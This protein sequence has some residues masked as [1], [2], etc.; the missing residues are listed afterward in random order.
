LSL[1]AGDL[2]VCVNLPAPA[3]YALHKL[4]VFGERTGAFATKSAKD[5]QQAASLLACLK[6]MRKSDVQRAWK[7][8]LSRG[9]GWRSRALAGV[10]ALDRRYPELGAAAWLK[11]P[12]R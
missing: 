4:L 11:A 1:S 9:K 6:V 2:V 7:D 5:L 3:R 10:K 8:L 12:E